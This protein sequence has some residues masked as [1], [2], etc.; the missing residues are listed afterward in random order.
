MKYLNSEKELS[1]RIEEIDNLIDNFEDYDIFPAE[2]PV[3]VC[4]NRLH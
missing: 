4:G 3:E 2:T 1:G